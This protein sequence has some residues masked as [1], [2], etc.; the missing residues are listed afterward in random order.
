MQAALAPRGNA[1][2]FLTHFVGSGLD[3]ERH[4]I[5][6]CL[7]RADDSKFLWRLGFRRL[8][9]AEQLGLISTPFGVLPSHPT[10]LGCTERV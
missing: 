4:V 1:H 6:R 3:D 8:G 2:T 7:P 9:C 5:Q 10:H